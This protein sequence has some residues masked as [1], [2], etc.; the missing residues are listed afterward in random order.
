MHFQDNHVKKKQISLT[1]NL[2]R[3]H[4]VGKENP[5]FYFNKYQETL[6]KKWKKYLSLFKKNLSADETFVIK[7]GHTSGIIKDRMFTSIRRKLLW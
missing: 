5:I 4:W 7:R 3:V 1:Q 2:Q 6:I